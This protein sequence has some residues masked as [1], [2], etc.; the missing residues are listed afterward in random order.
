MWF[1]LQYTPHPVLSIIFLIPL[2]IVLRTLPHEQFPPL[3][4]SFPPFQFSELTGKIQVLIWSKLDLLMKTG[5]KS[6]D[7][8]QGNSVCSLW[9]P[10]C[11]P[12]QTSLDAILCGT[13]IVV[14]YNN[15]CNHKST[16][17]ARARRCW[18][19]LKTCN[20]QDA[21]TLMV[22]PKLQYGSPSWT[23]RGSQ[24]LQASFLL[25]GPEVPPSIHWQD[26]TLLLADLHLNK[27]GQTKQC[28]TGMETQPFFSPPGQLIWTDWTR[29]Q[30]MISSMG[31]HSRGFQNWR[32]GSQRV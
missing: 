17:Q 22:S 23:F 2:I 14:A 8:A 19:G 13:V 26:V 11:A 10:G 12:F 15:Q 3:G 24:S 18:E 31:V 32:S 29:L 4:S 5:W 7:K 16:I 28:A 30:S 6:V 25:G 27:H 20:T 21:L 1:N 9:T